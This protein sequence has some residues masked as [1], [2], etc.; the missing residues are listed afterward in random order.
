MRKRH[1]SLVALNGSDD[2][3]AETAISL[4]TRFCHHNLIYATRFEV[5]RLVSMSNSAVEEAS[6]TLVDF[7]ENLD[8]IKQAAVE[9]RK[10]L[11]AMA[12]EKSALAK[13]DVLV[14]VQRMA[15]EAVAAAKGDAEKEA[16]SL[17]SK[18]DDSLKILKERISKKREAATELVIQR[19]L[20]Q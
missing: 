4:T 12:A 9:T 1:Y 11:S 2:G 17:I 7:E 5:L 18:G 10:K 14:Q 19:L 8:R 15:D 16:S 6:N 3:A 20:G 13:S